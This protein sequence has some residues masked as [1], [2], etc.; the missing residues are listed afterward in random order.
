MSTSYRDSQR[1]RKTYSYYRPVPRPEIM[2]T[3]TISEQALREL[4]W[5]QSVRAGSTADITILSTLTVLD[6]VT[7]NDGDRVLI[8]DQLTSSEN[9]IYDYS[10]VTQLLSRSPDAVQGTLSSG[11][12]CYI[13]EGSQAGS[14]WLLASIDPIVVGTT[15]LTWVLF[16]GSSIFVTSGQNART[17]YSASFGGTQ[18]PDQVGT[19]IFFYVSGSSEQKAVFGGDTVVSGVLSGSTGIFL[20]DLLE[21]GGNVEITGSLFVS[22]SS[23]IDSQM[24]QIS[25]IGSDVYFFVSGSIN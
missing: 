14:A 23:S 2:A 13:E 17:I 15:P 21:V 3:G 5:K 10:A 19:D 11:A 22:G 16:G 7:L 18:Y 4:D 6:G 24:R 25:Q 8:K 1:Y 20:S 9:G 12:A